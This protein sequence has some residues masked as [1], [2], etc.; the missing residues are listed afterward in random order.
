MA[1]ELKIQPN[2]ILPDESGGSLGAVDKM[3]PNTVY[4]DMYC[5][6]RWYLQKY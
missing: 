5:E 3:K 2:Y 1:D 4:N 6:N